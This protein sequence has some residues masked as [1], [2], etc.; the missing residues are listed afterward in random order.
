MPELKKNLIF[1]DILDL[2]GCKIVIESNDLKLSHGDLVLI[3]G[4]KVDNLY[5]LQGVIVSS[6]IV[7]TEKG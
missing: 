2:N 5:I 1:L 7:V 6:E 4:Q 3:K